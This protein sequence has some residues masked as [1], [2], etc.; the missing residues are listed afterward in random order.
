MRESW[1]RWGIS[2]IAWLAVLGLAGAALAGADGDEVT[3]SAT[4]SPDDVVEGKTLD[5]GEAFE[6]TLHLSALPETD[7]DLAIVYGGDPVGICQADAATITTNPEGSGVFTCEFTTVE[8]PGTDDLSGTVTFAVTLLGAPVTENVATITVRAAE[9]EE[10][11]EPE[12]TE[13]VE[14]AEEPD[15]GVNHGHCVSYWSHRAKD[16][17]LKGRAKGAFVSSIARDKDA[18]SSKVEDGGEPDDTCDFEEQLSE[19]LAE[20]GSNDEEASERKRDARSK[21]KGPKGADDSDDRDGDDEE[22][23][24][25]A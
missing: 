8:N 11:E 16:E 2:T 4:L 18:V 13:E 25:A 1:R 19:A 6:M 22:D 20:Q 5:S 7:Y 12:G 3:A 23:D 21:A 14:E 10:L 17:G 15:D 24:A 9:E